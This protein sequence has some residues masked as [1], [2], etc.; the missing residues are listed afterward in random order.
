MW[1][2]VQNI[3]VVKDDDWVKKEVPNIWELKLI[4]T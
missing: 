4:Q 2:W 1:P 3:I